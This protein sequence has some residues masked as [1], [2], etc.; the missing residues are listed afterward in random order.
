MW[1]KT[2]AEVGENES[3]NSD[4]EGH[5]QSHTISGSDSSS[6]ADTVRHSD[7]DSD[8]DDGEPEIPS[9][10]RTPDLP[11]ATLRFHCG[12]AFE[13]VVY[14]PGKKDDCLCVEDI[15]KSSKEL[16]LIKAPHDFDFDGFNDQ[17]LLLNA[18]QILRSRNTGSH[19]NR[20]KYNVMAMKM[21]S[22]SQNS[23]ANVLLPS[24][25]STELMP[26][27]AF[28]GQITI[29]NSVA[30][31]PVTLP[32]TPP[33]RTYELPPGLKQRYVPFG[34]EEPTVYPDSPPHSPNRSSPTKAP[35]TKGTSSQKKKKK[36][37]DKESS[38]SSAEDHRKAHKRKI[39]TEIKTE[40][41]D[42]EDS[43]VVVK[44]KKKHKH[45]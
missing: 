36:K 41:P 21:T 45:K 34:Y 6:D 11:D 23:P 4:N 10:V 16:W 25:N 38:S 26:G 12:N 17:E 8:N 24:R 31:L 2:M 3:N 40:I 14:Q 37:I 15:Q 7:D 9:R 20:K 44:K 22:N 28:Q 1:V 43:E 30:V 18:E 35:S 39:K 5:E 13:E 27:P 29:T 32:P 19:G 33:T 42:T